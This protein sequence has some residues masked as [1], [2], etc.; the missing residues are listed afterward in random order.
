MWA[1]AMYQTQHYPTAFSPPVTGHVSPTAHMRMMRIKD[2]HR[3]RRV[4][5][6]AP[7]REQFSL[8]CKDYF[9]ASSVSSLAPCTIELNADPSPSHICADHLAI[10][11][12]ITSQTQGRGPALDEP[13]LEIHHCSPVIAFPVS[14]PF[15]KPW[16][17][18]PSSYLLEAFV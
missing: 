10:L 12:K 16:A 14:P 11:Y 13:S 5:K 3:V 9:S 8:E 6:E 2:T 4:V 1:S 7:E 18:S 15:L 17:I